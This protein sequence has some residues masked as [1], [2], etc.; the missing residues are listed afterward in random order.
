MPK[1]IWARDPDRG[2]QTIPAPVK[3]RTTE[4]IEC[5][6]TKHFHGKYSRL[7][8]RFRGQFCYIDAFTDSGDDVYVPRGMSRREVIEQQR[9]TP[10]HLCRLRYFGN[11]DQWAFAFYKYSD[12]KYEL[13]VLN[14]GNFYGTPEEAFESAAVY[15]Q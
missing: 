10:T 9:S 13:C 7:G 14:S 4:R 11:D 12:E 3:R 6:A 15:L 2:G 5:Y 1:T 8:I